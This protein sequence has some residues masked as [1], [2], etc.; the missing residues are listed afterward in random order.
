METKLSDNAENNTVSSMKNT[1][2]KRRVVDFSSQRKQSIYL[3]VDISGSMC[4]DAIES[5]NVS[6]QS[7]FS[8]LKNTDNTFS[9]YLSLILFHQASEEKIPLTALSDISIPT[10]LGIPSTASFLGTAL[11]EL[12]DNIEEN[13]YS[14]QD[15]NN[16][17][18]LLIF[19]DGKLTDIAVFQKVITQIR[20]GYF[21]KI[22]ICIAG[23]IINDYLLKQFADRVV[24]LDTMGKMEFQ[25]LL[26]DDLEYGE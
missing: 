17:P 19:T 12:L 23:T 8:V 14:N 16:L 5:V 1:M 15:N 2:P 20:N 4:G 13:Y 6:L 24:S 9:W 26:C 22:I 21:Y 3:L 18:L 7:I 11:Q 10:I 25:R